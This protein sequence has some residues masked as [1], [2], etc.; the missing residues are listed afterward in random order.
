M[1]RMVLK[2]G[3]SR[4]RN[5]RRSSSGWTKTTVPRWRRSKRTTRPRLTVC[6][7][8]WRPTR[9]K[10]PYWARAVLRPA[11]VAWTPVVAAATTTRLRGRWRT[12]ASPRVD[13]EEAETRKLDR[14]P[15]AEPD[16]RPDPAQ[17]VPCEFQTSGGS[18]PSR[19]S[20]STPDF[21]HL[22]MDSPFSPFFYLLCDGELHLGRQSSASPS[23]SPPSSSP[24]ISLERVAPHPFS[25][26]G[27]AN[28][29]LESHAIRNDAAKKTT[30]VVTLSS[31][32]YYFHLFSVNCTLHTGRGRSRRM[33]RTNMKTN[34]NKWA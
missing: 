29:Q 7:R 15:E 8:A 21:R 31:F 34:R 14:D 9:R 33:K 18:P 2:L 22:L 30:K 6:C 12:R 4:S 24:C 32:V 23:S 20:S 25:V 17:T 27:C 5:W 11:S 1:T 13:Q 16:P 19:P 26:A 10:W 28:A 3:L